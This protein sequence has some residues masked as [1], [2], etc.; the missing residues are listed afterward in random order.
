MYVCMYVCIYIYILVCVCVQAATDEAKRSKSHSASLILEECAH[1]L[2]LAVDRLQCVTDT[3][4]DS[5]VAKAHALTVTFV[6][7]NKKKHTG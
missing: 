6:C 3:L 1:E 4:T 7:L 5:K 2:V